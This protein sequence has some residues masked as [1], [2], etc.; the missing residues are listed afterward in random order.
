[1]ND[2]Y[3]QRIEDYG[4][5][6]EPSCGIEHGVRVDQVETFWKF[7]DLATAFAEHQRMLRSPNINDCS[8]VMIRDLTQR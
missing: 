5:F 3:A 4:S 1:M 2:H 6:D 8:G 7:P